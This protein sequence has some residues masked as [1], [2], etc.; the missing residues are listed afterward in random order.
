LTGRDSR[1]SAA[2]HRLFEFEVRMEEQ[3]G[4]RV[5]IALDQLRQPHAIGVPLLSHMDPES[6]M[7]I[8]QQSAADLDIVIQSSI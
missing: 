6:L 3:R 4:S 2:I 5:P 8:C 7:Q 1:Q